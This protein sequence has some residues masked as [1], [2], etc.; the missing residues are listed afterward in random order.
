MASLETEG[1][2]MPD[3]LSCDDIIHGR[4]YTYH[5]RIPAT[6]HQDMSKECVLGIDE[7][8]RGPVLG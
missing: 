6:V 1:A 7:A 3:S 8:G 2:F 4:S 5:S